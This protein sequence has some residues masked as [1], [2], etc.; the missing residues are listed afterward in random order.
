MRQFP[1]KSEQL[2]SEQPEP[3]RDIA[4]ALWRSRLPTIEDVEARHAWQARYPKAAYR[5]VTKENYLD[6]VL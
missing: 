3:K 6:F 2:S 1:R 5:V 4:D